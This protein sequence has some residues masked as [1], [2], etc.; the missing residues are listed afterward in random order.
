MRRKSE[1]YDVLKWIAQTALP[2]FGALWF[3]LSEIWGFPYGEEIVGTV[4]ALDAC[5]GVLLGVSSKRWYRDFAEASGE[6]GGDE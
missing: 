1:T 6:E 5:L 4:T 2:A 3:A